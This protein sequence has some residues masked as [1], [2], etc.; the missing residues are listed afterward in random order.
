M[1]HPNLFAQSVTE[2]NAPIQSINKKTTYHA[3]HAV[4]YPTD[5]SRNRFGSSNIGPL[6]GNSAVISPRQAALDQ[7]KVPARKYAMVAMPGPA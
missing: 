1:I 2:M 4:A 5:S 7:I 6:T 3:I